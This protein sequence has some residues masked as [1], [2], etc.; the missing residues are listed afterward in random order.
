MAAATIV[1]EVATGLKAIKDALC[2]QAVFVLSDFDGFLL[3]AGGIQQKSSEGAGR[4]KMF[5][6]K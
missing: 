1:K 4:Q 5:L 6:C 2:E 3:N